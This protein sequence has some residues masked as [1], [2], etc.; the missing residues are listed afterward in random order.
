[1]RILTL[2]LLLATLGTPLLA[3]TAPAHGDMVP[4]AGTLLYMVSDRPDVLYRLFGQDPKGGWRLRSLFTD[5]LDRE[6]GDQKDSDEYKGAKQ[7][8]DYITGGYESLAQV[9]LGLCDITLDGPKYILHLRMKPGKAI[10][11]KPE[12]LAPFLDREIEYRG[13]K[14]VLYRIN[15]EADEAE[16]EDEM[17]R[18]KQNF[19][20]MD[21]YYVAD[22]GGSVL[23]SNFES[24]IREAMDLALTTEREEA[25]S[26][27]A[28]FKEWIAVRKPHDLSVFV[29][30]REIQ[31][32]IERLLPSKDQ[33]GVDAQKIY[34][35]I[36]AWIQFREY[37]YVVFDFD[38]EDKVRGITMAATLKTR[39]PT[40]LL[41]KFAIEP[42][43]FTALKYV[44]GNTVFKLGM[45]IGDAKTS[46]NNLTELARDLQKIA[47]ELES[48]GM[49]PFGGGR[50]GGT[51][52]ALPPE[53]E[54]PPEEGRDPAPPGEVQPE[55]AL[56]PGDDNPWLPRSMGMLGDLGAL[57]KAMQEEEEQP[58][59]P[60]HIEEALKE[61]DKALAEFGTTRDELLG[62]L[63]NQIVGF[64]AIDPATAGQGYRGGM[65][66]IMENGSIG[67]I[68]MLRDS[69]KAAEIIA[70]A[71]EKDPQGAFQ[72][73]KAVEHN[74]LSLHVSTERN[75]GYTIT[76][77]ALLISIS[78][79]RNQQDPSVPVVALLKSML[80]QSGR[81]QTGGFT[82]EG[83]KFIEMDLGLVARIELEAINARMRQLDRFAQPPLQESFARYMTGFTMQVRSRESKDGIEV[84]MRIEGL[85]DFGALVEQ[86]LSG[87]GSPDQQCYS[88]STDSLRQVANALRE[89]ETPDLAELVK[90]GKLRAAALQTPFDTRWQGPR[91]KLGWISLDSI[92]RDEE[93]GLPPW[94]DKAAVEAIEKNEKA[95]FNSYKL[96][97]G[98]AAALKD[99]ASGMI[100]IYQEK[101]EAMGGHL[102]VYGDGQVGWLHGDALPQALKLNADGKPVPAADPWRDGGSTPEGK[103]GS[104][105]ES[106]EP[107][108]PGEGNPWLP[109]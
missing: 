66:D 23:V 36:D 4:R 41:E 95:G 40:R 27:R 103:D 74:G 105:E 35:Q 13:S 55:K 43:T 57:L 51:G 84:A 54:M 83:S 42:A 79:D 50:R 46:F 81:T 15:K 65:G 10:D 63:G 100:V 98:A 24:T 29:I 44:P 45:Q 91:D 32:L 101:A 48:S 33:A 75:Y 64:M 26:A 30:G 90:A 14:Y 22:I 6:M 61:L 21:R 38:Y 3:Q 53:P 87:S 80:E 70:R 25:L 11:L 20:G 97:P 2:C 49:S 17:P 34:N 76:A 62:V 102:V 67:V 7:I 82:T 31:N 52:P 9:E 19:F 86:Q 78:M 28:E 72:G 37:R 96:A 71:R 39:R 68:I 5:S 8:L 12:F 77:D 16:G 85:P 106:R 56:P 108:K 93:G 59:P 99:F 58:A 1:M 60:D 88:F 18:P 92:N 107:M 69:K 109:E 73:M 89:Q 47:A 94:V 104:S